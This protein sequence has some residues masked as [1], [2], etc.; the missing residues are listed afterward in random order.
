MW[1]ALVVG[2]GHS[3]LVVLPISV[4]FCGLLVQC[5][6]TRCGVWLRASLWLKEATLLTSFQH[7]DITSMG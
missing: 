2:L 5:D 3:W 1:W 4:D 7:L 6:P